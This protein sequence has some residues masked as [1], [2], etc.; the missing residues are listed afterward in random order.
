MQRKNGQS[1]SVWMESADLP[2]Y[3]PLAAP[4]HAGVLIIGAGLAGITAAYC[5]AKDGFEVM[6]LEQGQVGSGDTART[7]AQITAILDKG[8]AET[9]RLRGEDGARLAA[10]SHYAAIDRIEG[11]VRE[12]GIACAFAR[13]DGYL[14]LGPGDS[15]DTLT[16]EL[17]AA[18]RAGIPDVELLAT[19]PALGGRMS[20]PVLRFP[21]QAHF[22]PLRY[23]ADLARAA[24][25]LGARIYGDTHVQTIKGGAVPF[26]ETSNGLTV[27]ADSIVIATHAPINDAIGYSTRVFPAMTYV[28]GLQLPRG[29]LPPFL[30]FD[31]ADPYHYVRIQQAT[32]HDLLIVGGEDHKTGQADDQDERY[33]RLEGWARQH[34]PQAG[35]PRSRWSGQVFNALDGLALIGP[36][37]ASPNVYVIAGQSGIGMTHSTIGGM[38]LADQIAGR[39]NP[40]AELYEPNRLPIRGLG[41]AL[42]EGLNVAAQYRDLLKGGDVRSEAEIPAGTG[43]VVGWG[44][45][46]LAVYRDEQ[47][48]V[49]RRSALCTHLGCVVAWNDAEKTWDCP[50]H[51]SRYTA[52]GKVMSGPAPADLGLAE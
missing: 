45:G 38:L 24:E 40:W 37:L 10:A 12:E 14:F 52:Y 42:S 29:S 21:R 23:L 5:L 48:V 6:V 19:A 13:V 30:A 32:E 28:V 50:C 27:T 1:R 47:G 26:I 31:T 15:A 4:E 51:G 16:N 43:A 17:V 49:H 41:E 44:P 39:Q 33:A 36:D 3:R 35:P 22:H 34:F 18:R 25:R 46:K 7:T 11:I 2:T 9:E 8:Y 20:G